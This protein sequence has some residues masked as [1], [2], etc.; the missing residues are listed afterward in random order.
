MEYSKFNQWKRLS[1]FTL[2]L[3]GG[4]WNT[5]ADDLYVNKNVDYLTHLMEKRNLQIA[6]YDQD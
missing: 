6:L 1:I 2:D 5:Y 3:N 4:I